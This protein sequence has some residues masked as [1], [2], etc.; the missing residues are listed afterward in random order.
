VRPVIIFSLLVA[1]FAAGCGYTLQ[2]T[3][4]LPYDSVTLGQIKN[5]TVEPKL[6]DRM[7]RLLAE[8]L[9]EYG[10]EIRPAAKYKIQGT[11]VKFALNPISEKSLTA[12]QYQVLIEGNFELIDTYAQ[13]A[14]PLMSLSSPFTTYFRSSGNLT[15]VLAEKEAATEKALKDL[16]QELV[17]RMIYKLPAKRVPADT[18]K[19]G[20]QKIEPQAVPAG[21]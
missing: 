1:I 19:K 10:F 2:G 6:Q 7:S 21:K 8:T 5:T 20:E 17:R 9:L 16:S 4:N 3:A 13:K 11:I 15:S 18:E 14:K 12:I